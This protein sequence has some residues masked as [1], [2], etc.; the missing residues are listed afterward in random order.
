MSVHRGNARRFGVLAA[1]ALATLAGTAVAQPPVYRTGFADG[2]TS[3]WSTARTLASRTGDK[4]MGRFHNE[5]VSLTLDALPRHG[6][7]VVA[8]DVHI[9][10]KWTGESR[11]GKPATTL[12]IT[13]DDGT[14]LCSS[15][16]NDDG[17]PSRRQS[18][19]DEPDASNRPAALGAYK[20]DALGLIDDSGKPERDSVYRLVFAAPH[21][22]GAMKLTLSA[23]NLPGTV[24]DASWAIDNAVV[25]T[26]ADNADLDAVRAAAR[27]A[28]NRTALGIGGSFAVPSAVPAVTPA[29]SLPSAPAAPRWNP[30][31]IGNLGAFEASMRPAV[32][33]GHDS[34][35]ANAMDGESRSTFLPR[36]DRSLSLGLAQDLA[37]AS[38]R[39]T[40]EF[41]APAAS[42][43]AR[44]EIPV[45]RRVSALVYQSRFNEAPGAQWDSRAHGIAPHGERFIGP[46]VSQPATLTLSDIPEHDQL[47]IDA[48]F[49]AIGD[50]AGD[51]PDP[52]KFTFTLD[53]QEVLAATFANEDGSGKRTQSYPVGASARTRLPGTDSSALDALGFPA[54]TKNAV[55]DATYHLRFVVPHSKGAAAL[56][57]VASGLGTSGT[58]GAWG[59]DNVTVVS[60][61]DRTMSYSD[62]TGVEPDDNADDGDYM[63]PFVRAPG[64]EWNVQ[65]FETSPSGEMFLGR[66]HNQ[67]AA[68][69]VKNFPQHT[70]M[71]VAA[72]VVVVGDWQG[73]APDPSN[74]GIKL[75]DG[76]VVLATSFATDG[77]ASNATQDYP[78]GSNGRNL[79]GAGAAAVGSMG[80]KDAKTGV[81]RD[82]V[83]RLAFTIPHTAAQETISFTVSGLRADESKASWG[84]DNVSVSTFDAANPAGYAAG[85]GNTALGDAGALAYGNPSG[86]TIG[87]Y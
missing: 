20:L 62:A 59:L 73:N 29:S 84:L 28:V 45:T 36:D 58:V 57:F 49:Y 42:A 19:P 55:G 2:A 56:K 72:D 39:Y 54:P 68:L 83:Y 31:P 24:N 33:T 53:G 70:H 67:T 81:A 6:T 1:A 5:P 47:I 64:P 30:G 15:F 37:L 46:F 22:A 26:A 21:G 86:G 76:T 77:G 38:E 51:A 18:F 80:Y 74:F 32:I 14:L 16:A 48:D 66:L 3:G 44:P 41:A 85:G 79:P 12:T 87:G 43:A 52:S 82:A 4:L 61:G 10:G 40:A 13:L 7:V 60:S 9:I 63:N 23:S 71:V 69:T 34:I 11:A 27:D 75:A 35:L 25:Y 78:G 50:W 8:M 65:K 17:D